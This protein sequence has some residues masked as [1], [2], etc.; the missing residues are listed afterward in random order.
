MILL[1]D[2]LLMITIHSRKDQR[3][4]SRY[5]CE[6]SVFN[7]GRGK[8]RQE[9]QGLNRNF[10]SETRTARRRT[11]VVTAPIVL[12]LQPF[13]LAFTVEISDSLRIV[14]SAKDQENEINLNLLRIQ[15]SQCI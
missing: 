7:G 13:L 3:G 2:L 4:M 9:N 12:Q 14:K 8:V 11:E 6:I 10:K 5:E 1:T 15:D